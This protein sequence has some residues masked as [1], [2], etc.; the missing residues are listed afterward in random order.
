VAEDNG[1]SSRSYRPSAIFVT[2]G[3]GAERDRR[4]GAPTTTQD[5]PVTALSTREGDRGICFVRF[6]PRPPFDPRLAFAD[7]EATRPASFRLLRQRL[8]DRGDARTILCTS[9]HHGEGKTTLA[10]N[11]ALAFSELGR[12]RV[13]LLEASFRRVAIA[14]LFGFDIP[15]GFRSQIFRHRHNRDEP[16][17]MIQVGPPPLYIMAAE[18]NG[19]IKCGV[20]AP[21]EARFCGR[22]GGAVTGPGTAFGD[23]A[24]FTAALDR[25]RQ[26]FDYVIIDGPSVLT[27]GDVNL[28]QD[29]ADAVV[30]A[31][32]KG[33]SDERSLR[34]AIDQIA[35]APLAGVTMFE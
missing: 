18:L 35:P 10:V 1:S 14:S 3:L 13:L 9:A 21:A 17:I 24:G 25:F 29:T 11:L 30:F 31:A 26:A 16:W 19:C 7:Q 8:I 27:G 34:R 15:S 4:T 23:W 2:G 33:Q 20:S 28:M 5:A 12:H 22:C 6:V 32:R